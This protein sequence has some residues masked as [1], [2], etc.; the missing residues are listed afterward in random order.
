MLR[1]VPSAAVRSDPGTAPLP[2]EAARLARR[3]RGDVDTIVGKAL[4]REPERRYPSAAALAEDLA[5]HLDGRPI[6]AR[7]D[8]LGYQ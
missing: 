1:I 4:A 7:P 8:A 5:R 2:L 3:L 6:A